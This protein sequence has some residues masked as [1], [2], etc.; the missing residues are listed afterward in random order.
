MKYLSFKYS[1]EIII[2]QIGIF[3]LIF[4]LIYLSLRK[5]N[6]YFFNIKSIDYNNK[7]NNKNNNKKI[8]YKNVKDKNIAKILRVIYLFLIFSILLLDITLYFTTDLNY[9]RYFTLI[10]IMFSID[11]ILIANLLNTILDEEDSF[12]IE[13]PDKENSISFKNKIFKKILLKILILIFLLNILTFA[14]I[15]FFK[16]FSFPINFY[17]I[18]ILTFFLFFLL[19]KFF[20]NTKKFRENKIDNEGKENR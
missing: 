8:K 15:F 12:Y 3:L 10:S 13:N 5:L 19:F 17:L 16:Y 1:N 11:I 20:E 6:P 9:F 2:S 14:L 18:L 4:F 7:N